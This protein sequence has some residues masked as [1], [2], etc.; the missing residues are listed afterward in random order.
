MGKRSLALLLVCLG[1]LLT[2]SLSATA[3]ADT[4]DVIEPQ[5]ETPTPADGFQAGTCYENQLG[6]VPET[7]IPTKPVDTT[8]PF[9]SAA[10]PEIF[11]TQAGG[12][13]PFGFDQYIVRHET[14]VAG[15]VE[16]LIEDPSRSRFR[17][18]TGC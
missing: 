7:P 13:P 8:K 14:Q 1:A 11:F 16:P 10:T 9:C 15:V 5:H 3:L 4:G 17:S 6:E 2:V 12:H 18:K